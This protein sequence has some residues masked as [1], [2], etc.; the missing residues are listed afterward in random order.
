[1]KGSVI[2]LILFLAVALVAP[3]PVSGADGVPKMTAVSPDSGKVGDVMKASGEFL[4]KAH[5]AEVY[6]TDGTTDWKVVIT[7]QSATEI[8]FKVPPT[9][10]PGRFHLMVLTPGPDAKL[11][12]E[13]VRVTIQGE[14]P[15]PS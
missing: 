6:I 5:V 8:E 2:L 4:D 14:A 15:T 7:K 12:E 1:M 13:P 9:A 11:I 3:A 10:K